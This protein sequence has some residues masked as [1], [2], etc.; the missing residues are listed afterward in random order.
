[1]SKQTEDCL[2]EIELWTAECDRG[3][4]KIIEIRQQMDNFKEPQLMILPVDEP[5]EEEDPADDVI[6]A[7][8]GDVDSFNS[9]YSKMQEDKQK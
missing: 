4:E 5:E 1:M 9:K 8:M 3:E 7:I 6:K 2:K